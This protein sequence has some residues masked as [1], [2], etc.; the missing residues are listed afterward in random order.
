MTSKDVLR[1]L[2]KLGAV[3]VRQSGSHVIVRA[4]SCMTP[5]PVHSG[6]DIPKGTLRNIEKLMTPALGERWLTA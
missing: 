2:R 1:R 6:K 4:G 5:V 3:E